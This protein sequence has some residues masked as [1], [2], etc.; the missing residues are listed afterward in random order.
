MIYHCY[1]STSNSPV[2][3]EQKLVWTQG[4]YKMGLNDVG[5]CTIQFQA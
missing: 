3:D 1:Q 5:D 4:T 2:V